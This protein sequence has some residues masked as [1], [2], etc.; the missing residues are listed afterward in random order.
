MPGRLGTGPA[1]VC[2]E[3]QCKP[4]DLKFT[5]RQLGLRNGLKVRHRELVDVFQDIASR[6]GLYAHLVSLI[7]NYHVIQHPTAS[8]TKWKTFYDQ[9][10]SALDG[11][12]NEFTTSTQ[13]F[14]TQ[15]GQSMTPVQTA[16]QVRAMLPTKLKFELRQNET[17]QMVVSSNAH[18]GLFNHRLHRYLLVRCIEAMITAGG[19][20]V[21]DASLFQAIYQCVVDRDVEA[22]W[23]VV[24]ST[25]RQL[26]TSRDH[27]ATLEAIR[28]VILAE[29]QSLGD[30]FSGKLATCKMLPPQPHYRMVLV[31]VVTKQLAPRPRAAFWMQSVRTRWTETPWRSLISQCAHPARY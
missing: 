15:V 7:A 31:S 5:T 22:K 11:S 29:R 28:A 21:D 6:T 3:N 23:Y 9:I 30:V 25:Y 4:K 17:A 27:S 1:Q 20:V 10:W 2:E 13:Q 16:L 19:D 24:E 18:F 8:I 14:L 26:A 12:E